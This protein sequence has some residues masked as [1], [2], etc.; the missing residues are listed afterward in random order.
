M[1]NELIRK[2]GTPQEVWSAGATHSALR[3]CH[4][5]LCSFTAHDDTPEPHS[6]RWCHGAI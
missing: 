3:P 4:R 1:L 5:Q 6:N 2:Y